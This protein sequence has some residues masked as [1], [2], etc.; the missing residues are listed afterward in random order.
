MMLSRE[1]SALRFVPHSKTKLTPFEDYHG[2]EDDIAL[3]NLTKKHSLK[4]LDSKNVNK[5]KL[6][7]LY[8]AKMPP[9]INETFAKNIY[10]T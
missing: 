5:Q 6:H 1:L 9:N 2:Q 3:R 7:C 10:K 8:E 4:N